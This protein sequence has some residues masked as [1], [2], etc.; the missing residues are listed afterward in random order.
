MDI[1]WRLCVLTNH[2]PIA[3]LDMLFSSTTNFHDFYL[4]IYYILCTP[5]LFSQ[6]DCFLV[7]VIRLCRVSFMLVAC[8]LFSTFYYICLVIFDCWMAVSC[9][10]LQND[11]N[12]EKRDWMTVQ[13]KEL[14]KGS[15]LVSAQ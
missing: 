5:R 3:D 8:C 2:Y 7:S 13:P 15:Q 10:F 6:G 9:L 14:P 11:F 1:S 12:F 4:F